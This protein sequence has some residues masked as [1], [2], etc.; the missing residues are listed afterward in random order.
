VHDPL[1]DS[2]FADLVAELRSARVATPPALEARVEALVAAA[3]APPA[4]RPARRLRLRPPSR[5]VVVATLVVALGAAGAALVLANRP[6]GSRSTSRAAAPPRTTTVA[7]AATALGEAVGVARTAAPTEALG[8]AQVPTAPTPKGPSYEPLLKAPPLTSGSRYQDYSGDLRVAVSSADA[9]AAATARVVATT[10]RLGGYVLAVD[11]GQAT[12]AGG[13]SSLD[14]RVPIARVQEA[15]AAFSALGRLEAE[16]AR[17][18]DVQGT[19]DALAARIAAQRVAVAKLR[20]QVAQA[21]PG[22]V[23][24]ATL[25][26]RLAEA[27]AALARSRRQRASAIGAASYAALHVGVDLARA[28]RP[29][30]TVTHRT[31]GVG[32]SAR[33]ALSLLRRLG[34]GTVFAAIVLAPFAL[35]AAAAVVA[36]RVLRRR[37]EQHLLEHV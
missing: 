29:Q 30:A 19:V 6:S 8:A 23:D 32:G 28:K 20:A 34:E 33:H 18:V 26:V 24:R 17:V 31:N 1:V 3:S 5:R 22:S 27:Q 21:A 14:V 2:R 10:R 12:A 4:P 13:S 15:L 25:G 16:H 7:K 36:W 37:R 11:Y 9:L 35:V